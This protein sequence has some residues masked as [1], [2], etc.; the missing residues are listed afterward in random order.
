MRGK[1]LLYHKNMTTKI[2]IDRALADWMREIRRQLHRHPELSGAEHQTCSFIL[3]RL[4]ELGIPARRVHQTGALADLGPERGAAVALRA[5]I[6]ALPIEEATG[7]EFASQNQ[8]VMHACGHDGH[9]AML[10]GAAALLQKSGRLSGP[11]RLIFQ[12]AEEGDG[13]AL[14]MIAAGALAGVKSIFSGHIDRHFP[15]GKI[16][17]EPGI[18]C[19]STDDFTIEFRG[20]GGHAAKPHES[21]DCI[22]SAAALVLNL[23]TL[24]SRARDPVT[25]AVLTV[26]RIQGG[27]AANVIAAETAI[28][29]TIRALDPQT[30]QMLLHGLEKMART[31]ARSAGLKVEVTIRPGCPPLNNDPG[32]TA[33]ARQVAERRLGAAMVPGLLAPSM[34]G[35]DFAFYLREVPGCLVRFGAGKKRAPAGPAHSPTFDFNEK[36]LPIGAAFLAEVALAALAAN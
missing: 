24:I 18:I 26:G 12:P 35:E 25:P 3:A 32:A 33:L 6:D 19:A 11:V 8:G 34:G 36:V 15:V 2:P 4:A 9:V 17:V 23:Q 20:P 30:R 21:A 14:G 5:D 29:G 13:G 31:A 28:S 16:A 27:S 1:F 10:L 7:L 22:V